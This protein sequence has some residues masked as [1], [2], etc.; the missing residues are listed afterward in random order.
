MHKVYINIDVIPELYIVRD[1]TV[2]KTLVVLNSGK[3]EIVFLK[4]NILSLSILPLE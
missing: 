1:I 4:E 2:T 3:D